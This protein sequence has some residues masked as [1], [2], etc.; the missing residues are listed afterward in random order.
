[1]RYA[2]DA[3]VTR[4]L[5]RALQ[6]HGA[7]V[8]WLG[9]RPAIQDP[10]IL[11]GSIAQDCVLI[12]GDTDFG[13]LVFK[14]GRTAIGVVLVRCA[15]ANAAQIEDVVRRILALPNGGRGAFTTLDKKRSRSRPIPG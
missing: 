7:V 14:Q 5:E 4:Q 8:V 12:T 10:D 1:M 15:T 3:C 9:G 13:E 2:L 11:Q 6:S